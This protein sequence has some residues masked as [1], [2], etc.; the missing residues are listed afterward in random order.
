M[1]RRFQTSAP[2]PA[3]HVLA[4]IGDSHTLNKAFGLVGVEFY[5]YLVQ[6]GLNDLACSVVARNLGIAGETTAQMVA[7]QT[8]LTQR[9]VPKLVIIYGG[10]NDRAHDTT[11]KATPTPTSTVFTLN[12][13]G[14]GDYY[15]AGAHILVDGEAA[16]VESVDGDEITLTAALAGGAPAGGETVVIDTTANL[17]AIGAYAVASGCVRILVVGQHYLNWTSGGDTT[18]AQQSAAATLRTQQSDAATAIQALITA[19]GPPSASG[20]VYVDTYAGFSA[21]IGVSEV[22][23]DNGIHVLTDNT[24]LNAHGESAAVADFIIAA[25]VAQTGW[26]AALK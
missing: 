10:A 24:H 20:G 2:R 8:G 13:A 9:E 19:L 21:L 26:V 3:K 4:A 6:E 18:V 15:G 14:S 23:G 22:Q 16:V 7:R 25:I 1:P 17:T 12:T 5:P 11:V